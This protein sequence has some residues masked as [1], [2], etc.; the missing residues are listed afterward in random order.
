M[1]VKVAMAV[2]QPIENVTLVPHP[3][4]LHINPL[5]ASIVKMTEIAE[6]ATHPTVRAIAAVEAAVTAA[7]PAKTAIPEDQSEQRKAK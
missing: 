6:T 3:M 1:T 2:T 5:G 4:P 7:A